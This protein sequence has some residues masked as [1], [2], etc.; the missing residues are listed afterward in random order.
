MDLD[1]FVTHQ[2]IE[3]YRKLSDIATDE[4]QRRVIFRLLAEE[5]EKFKQLAR[6]QGATPAEGV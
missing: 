5:L 3:R 6:D 1:H 2:N 4:P